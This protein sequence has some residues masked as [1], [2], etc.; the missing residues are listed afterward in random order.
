MTI[1]EINDQ[2]E[3]FFLQNIDEE[4]GEILN[5]E[6]FSEL[7]LLREEKIENKTRQGEYES[8][9]TVLINASLRHKDGNT[10]RLAKEL[11]GK[12]NGEAQIVNL[13]LYRSKPEELMDIIREASTL[14]MCEPLYV[15]GL[16]SL[17]IKMMERVQKQ[18]EGPA[19]RVYAL[20]NMGLYESRQLINLLTAIRQWSQEMGFEY[21]GALGVGAGELVG[22]LMAV[23][24]LTSWPLAEIGQGMKR[25]AEAVNNKES[26]E[27]IYA[28]TTGFPKWLYMAIANSGWKRMAKKN[29]I[30]PRE[31]FRRL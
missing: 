18:Y 13:A 28:E 17:M 27:D 7:E 20:A 10:A 4:T 21:G 6:K 26:V 3:Q 9:K 2:I 5:P 30:E 24:K 12:L 23:E 16:P 14:V 31:L 8:E 22:G 1:Y 15:D 29:G 19:K 11:T 25:L